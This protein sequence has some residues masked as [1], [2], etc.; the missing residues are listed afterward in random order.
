MMEQVVRVVVAAMMVVRR[1]G[2]VK[3]EKMEVERAVGE[4]VVEREVVAA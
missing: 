1:V 3:A 2:E 4:T